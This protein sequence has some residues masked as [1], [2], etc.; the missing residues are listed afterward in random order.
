MKFQN[1][2]EQKKH[3]FYD[4]IDF[5]NRIPMALLRG[6]RVPNLWSIKIRIEKIGEND[7]CSLQVLTNVRCYKAKISQQ[8]TEK[9][10]QAVV[11]IVIGSLHKLTG[12]KL[13]LYI[14]ENRTRPSNGFNRFQK[15]IRQFWKIP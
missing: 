13:Q 1:N 2:E 14:F 7:N 3:L 15:S 5:Y 8:R 4:S 12:R 9:E 6:Y 11:K 10:M